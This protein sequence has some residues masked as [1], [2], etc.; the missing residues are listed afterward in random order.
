MKKTIIFLTALLFVLVSCQA[1]QPTKRCEME[2]LF[3]S[4]DSLPS[5]TMVDPIITPTSLSTESGTRTFL[6]G[7]DSGIQ[8]VARFSYSRTARNLFNQKRKTFFNDHVNWI[9]ASDLFFDDHANRYYVACSEQLSRCIMIS[10]YEEYFVFLSSQ[11]SE[12]SITPELFLNL[13][14][15]IDAKMVICFQN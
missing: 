11:I 4:E 6:I 2:S 15:T 13:T 5:N 9:K 7:Q 8:G 14:K 12:I 10:Q 1:E 3:L